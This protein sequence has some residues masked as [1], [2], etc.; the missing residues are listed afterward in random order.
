MFDWF[1]SALERNGVRGRLVL[2]DIDT[3]AAASR[4]ADTFL[5]PPPVHSTEYPDWLKGALVDHDIQLAISVN[6]FE[7][8]RWAT[9]VG[10]AWFAPLVCLSSP[11]QR[12]VEDKL[13]AD[14]AFRRYGIDVPDTVLAANFSSNSLATATHG[15]VSKGRYGSASRGLRVFSD[16]ADAQSVFGSA[17]A[18][19]TDPFGETPSSPENALDLLVVQPRVAGWEYGLDVV[20]NFNGEFTSVLARRKLAMRGGETDKAISVDSDMFG[21]LAR[22]ISRAIPHRGTI[23]VDVIVDKSGKPWVIDVNP[24]FGGGYPFS[25]AA[26]ADVPSAYVA[27]ALGREHD[28]DWLISAPGIVGAKSVTVEL[29]TQGGSSA[30]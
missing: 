8:G 10:P 1:R 17:S 14:V 19:V 15:F 30:R 22:K 5:T 20:A 24:R 16:R 13:A 3:H 2:S 26:G 23:D 9:L 18:E 7:L 21:L 4:R 28:P 11:A 29:L 12:M 27:W 6:D 25:H